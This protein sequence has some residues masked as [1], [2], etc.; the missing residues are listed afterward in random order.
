MQ[1][2][3][4]RFGRVE[5]ADDAVIKFPDGLIGLPGTRYALIAQTESSV[6]LWL[7]SVDDPAVAL[8][9]TNPWL[10]FGNYEVEVS[11][12]DAE[13][14]RLEGPANADILCVVRAS[15]R[16][17]EFTVNLRGPLVVQRP[18][19]NRPSDHQR[20][21]RLLGTAAAVLRDRAEPRPSVGSGRPRRCHG[22]LAVLVITRRSG[23]R[24][25]L[26]DD[27]TVTV[28]EISGSTVRLGIEAPS[29]VPVYRH[30][31]WAAVKAENQ[32]A[33][34]ASIT[35]LPTPTDSSN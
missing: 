6:F 13:K 19:A 8:P 25:C 31:I 10:F 17:E 20:D 9:V 22:G 24:I 5:I 35:R 11:D 14:L 27:I 26:G 21:R 15:D 23:E 29:E 7:H 33:A 3:S 2:E 32:A 12:E 30:E 34:N 28:L 18:G 16:L 4:T 1:I